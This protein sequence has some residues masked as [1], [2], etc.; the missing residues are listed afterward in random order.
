MGIFD[1]EQSLSF[2]TRNSRVSTE[3]AG[4]RDRIRAQ[5]LGY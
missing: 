3:G 1:G 2:S 5:E 4:Y